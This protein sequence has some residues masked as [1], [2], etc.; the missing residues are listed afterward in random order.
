MIKCRAEDLQPFRALC[1]LLFDGFWSSD[2]LDSKKDD[3]PTM[4]SRWG[5]RANMLGW[6]FVSY[7]TSIA[8]Y[9][10]EDFFTL[11]GERRLPECQ[12]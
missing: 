5:V 8:I 3:A 9:R 10:L 2:L 11:N 6:P 4:V 1:E 7:N 12:L